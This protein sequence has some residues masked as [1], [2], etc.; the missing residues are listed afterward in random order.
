MVPAGRRDPVDRGEGGPRVCQVTRS[1]R[2]PG[3]PTCARSRRA[4]RRSA[5]ATACRPVDGVKAGRRPVE[6]QARQC[7]P[8]RNPLLPVLPRRRARRRRREDT[9]RPQG[10]GAGHPAAKGNTGE[11]MT[12]DVLKVNGLDYKSL[13]K[14]NPRFAYNDAV[15]QMKDGHAQVFGADTT[16]PASAVMDLASARD[17]RS[18]CW[19]C[20]TTSCASCRRSTRATTS[21]S[22]RPAAIRSRTRTIQTIGTWTHLVVSCDLPEDQVYRMTKAWPR[23]SRRSAPW[24]RRRGDQRQGHGDRHRRALPHRGAEVLQGSEARSS[25]RLNRRALR[26]T[27]A[28]EPPRFRSGGDVAR[29]PWTRRKRIRT[30]TSVAASMSIYHMIHR[31]RSARPRRCLPRHAPAVHDDPGVPALSRGWPAGASGGG[32]LDLLCIACRWR[33]SPTS[34]STTTN[35]RTASSTSTI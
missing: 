10:Q 27:G 24:S 26:C 3:S 22:S 7:L 21:A 18:A 25:R 33:R 5:S 30:I 32:W 35:C 4:R 12:R 14:V 16:V 8:G 1:R 9:R 20:P 13:S 31:G 28:R 15:D 29:G 19:R 6:G 23:T 34:G 11:E 17:V 2:V